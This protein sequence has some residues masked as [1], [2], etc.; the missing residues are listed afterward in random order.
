MPRKKKLPE[1]DFKPRRGRRRKMPKGHI[2]HTQANTYIRCPRFYKIK[3]IDEKRPESS[4][5]MKRGSVMHTALK[6]LNDLSAKGAGQF[7]Y[8][9]YRRAFRKALR[10]ETAPGEIIPRDVQ[11]MMESLQ[12]IGEDIQ[13][14]TKTLV[15]AECEVAV[16]FQKGLKL[17]VIIDRIDTWGSDGL[18]LTDYKYGMNILSKAELLR[19]PQLNIYALAASIINPAIKRFKLTQ[20]MLRQRFP[21]SVEISVDDVG[22]VREH[23]EYVIDGIEAGHFEPRINSWCHTCPDRRPC[24]AYKAR[25][26]ANNEVIKNTKQAHEVYMDMKAKGA[27][28]KE[29][30]DLAKNYMGDQVE[31]HGRLSVSDGMEWDFWAVEGKERDTK[32]TVDTFRLFGLCIISLLNITNKVYDLCRRQLMAK[33]SQR[34]IDEFKAAE[35]DLVKRKVTTRLEPRKKN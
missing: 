33:L 22:G 25:F 16:D 14:T 13:S 3:Y 21:N 10:A 28:I 34:R 5:V 4:Y 29:S 31:E 15:D 24:P 30:R 17:L 1:P 2:S 23:L 11:E 6:E 26:I 35:K 18:E 32:K 19:D 27:L 8:D 20:Y 9:D 7:G 12:L